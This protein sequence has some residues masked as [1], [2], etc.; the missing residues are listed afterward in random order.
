MEG[1][2]Y[3]EEEFVV[4]GSG[5]QGRAFVH[6]DDVVDGLVAAQEKGLGQGPIQLGPDT[7]TSIREIAESVVEISGKAIPIRYDTTK[8]EGDR[9][10]CADYTKAR[11]VLGWEP[12]VPLR[13]A[14]KLCRWIGEIK[15]GDAALALR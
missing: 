6:V 3:P 14:T 7:C 13:Q 4:C 11:R 12:C 2:R 10:R 5:C 8:P 15:R 1:I 9:G